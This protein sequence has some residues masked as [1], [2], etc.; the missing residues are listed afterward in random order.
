MLTKELAETFNIDIKE[1][2]KKDLESL[3][4][5][6]FFKYNQKK[7]ISYYYLPR[8]HDLRRIKSERG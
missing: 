1:L 8:T 4:L 6:E 7:G 2:L 3:D 5:S